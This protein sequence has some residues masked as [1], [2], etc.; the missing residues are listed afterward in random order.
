[1]TE[2][3][4]SPEREFSFYQALFSGPEKIDHYDRELGGYLRH[5]PPPDGVVDNAGLQ[6]YLPDLLLPCYIVTGEN[7]GRVYEITDTGE[8]YGAGEKI[9]VRVWN[10]SGRRR[11]FIGTRLIG[12]NSDS[13]YWAVPDSVRK[14]SWVYLPRKE[15]SEMKSSWP[16]IE[17]AGTHVL[18]GS[19]V[20]LLGKDSRVLAMGIF[21]GV[22]RFEKDSAVF[23]DAQG[24]G[25]PSQVH[26]NQVFSVEIKPGLPDSACTRAYNLAIEAKQ[27]ALSVAKHHVLY[28]S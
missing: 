6:E 20:S 5:D 4:E 27:R 15:K 7:G 12:E 10:K 18:P 8:K 13:D 24:R 17:V 3:T 22:T 2:V 25:N 28:L 23:V 9:T 21:M 11:W 14:V 1:M 19:Q 26:L 16:G